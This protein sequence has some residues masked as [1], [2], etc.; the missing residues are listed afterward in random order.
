MRSRRALLALALLCPLLLVAGIYLGGHPQLL[1]GAARDT[2]VADS[3]AQLY[4]EAMD[5]IA[6]D[7]YRPV[8]RRALVNRSLTSAVESLR[9]DFSNYFSPRDYTNFRQSTNGEFVGVGISVEAADRLKRGLRVLQVY[10][11]SPAK[12]AGL[13]SGDLV[14]RVNGRATAGQS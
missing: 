5:L 12:R 4:E 2:L 8:D 6:E 13:R 1:P 14:T 7:Y 3:D 10:D 9:D 11:G